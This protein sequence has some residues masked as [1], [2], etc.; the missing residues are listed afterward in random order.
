MTSKLA[1]AVE[2]SALL[3]SKAAAIELAVAAN[4][5]NNGLRITLLSAKRRAE[6]AES[7]VID[8]ARL[9]KGGSMTD[10]H[11]RLIRM[12]AEAKAGRIKIDDVGALT[13]E[14]AEE[15]SDLRDR[16]LALEDLLAESFA[17]L[18]LAVNVTPHT[19]DATTG[20]AK[21]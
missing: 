15:I 5:N 21:R 6:S 8:F 4:P 1:D 19:L 10:I 13:Y 12:H 14:A 11:E 16:V 2:F 9:A 7:R 17:T 20:S 3:R 18:R